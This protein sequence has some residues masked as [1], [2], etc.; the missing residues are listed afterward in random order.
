MC[1]EL[2]GCADVFGVGGY[3]CGF[4][5]CGLGVFVYEGEFVLYGGEVGGEGWY[6]CGCGGVFGAPVEGGAYHV[7]GVGVAVLHL[8]FGFVR[9]GA[10]KLRIFVVCGLFVA[11]VGRFFLLLQLFLILLL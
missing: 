5:E 6:C 3:A 10:K 1:D 2:H 9:K 7:D 8:L 11:K 4:F